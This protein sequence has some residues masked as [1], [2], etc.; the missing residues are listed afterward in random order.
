MGG[1]I[2]IHEK[3]EILREMCVLRR[4]SN[5]VRKGFESR[6]IEVRVYIS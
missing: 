2:G 6:E 3:F 1:R 4:T 5:R